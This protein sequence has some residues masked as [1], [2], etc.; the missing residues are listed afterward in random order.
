M[1]LNWSVFLSLSR[2]RPLITKGDDDTVLEQPGRLK[3]S[4]SIIPTQISVP[5]PHSAPL[6]RPP[7]GYRVLAYGPGGYRQV[8]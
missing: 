5:L 4:L 3:F 7:G 1:L 6:L 8:T 2:S